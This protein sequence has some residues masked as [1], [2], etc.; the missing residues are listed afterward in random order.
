MAF[1]TEDELLRHFVD[2]GDLLDAETGRVYIS[3][4]GGE[5]EHFYGIMVTDPVPNELWNDIDGA[6]E[7]ALGHFPAPASCHPK[8]MEF[9][10]APGCW[11]G[12]LA[13]EVL[14]EPGRFID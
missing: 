2:G 8:S 3:D 1:A 13:R 12:E 5:D 10:E 9:M 11:F 7:Y 4:I 6:V 14:R